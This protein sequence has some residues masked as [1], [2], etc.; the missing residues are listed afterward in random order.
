MREAG[1]SLADVRLAGD[2][3]REAL[4][5]V[6]TKLYAHQGRV[7]DERNLVDW[8]TRLTAVRELFGMFD[9]RG[10]KKDTRASARKIKVEV[11]LAP[12]L[13]RLRATT[14]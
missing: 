14:G 5:A 4:D 2:R 13:K 10:S 9:L 12:D 6:E 3:L 11:D 8:T 7:V 1:L